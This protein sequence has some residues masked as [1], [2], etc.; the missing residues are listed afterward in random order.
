VDT[1]KKLSIA[2]AAAAALLFALCAMTLASGVSQQWFEW[3]RPPSEYAA[4]LV[5]DAAWLRAIIAVDDVFI[6]SYVTATV[7][8]ANVLA[9]GEL[10]V[11][12]VL[13]I[14]GGVAAG[15]LDLAE[16]HH[17]LAMLR[18]A[19]SGEAIPL[20]EILHRSGASQLKWMLGH[21]SFALVGVALPARDAMTRAFRASLVAWQLPI[22]ALYWTL[23]AWL[24]LLTW[25]RYGSLFAGFAAIAWLTRGGARADAAAVGSSARA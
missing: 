7:L 13:V 21:L 1:S 4:R 25:L 3:V 14:A 20:G 17:I 16:N 15:V 5:R 23:D 22:G 9:R 8:L 12:H 18:V 2:S 6:A 19:E 24:P 11:V 10:G